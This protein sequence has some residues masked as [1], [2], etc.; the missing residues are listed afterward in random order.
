MKTYYRVCIYQV[1]QMILIYQDQEVR[2]LATEKA[3]SYSEALELFAKSN[4]DY[5]NKVFGA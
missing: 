3:V 4:S 2:K 1:H 5:Y